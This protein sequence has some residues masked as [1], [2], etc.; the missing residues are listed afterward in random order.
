MITFFF[1]KH[2]LAISFWGAIVSIALL[3]CQ[4]EPIEV[5]S[6]LENRWAG[7]WQVTSFQHDGA[8]IKDKVVVSSNLH[9]RPGSSDSNG[10]FEWSIV[11]HDNDASEN[12]TGSYEI[13]KSLLEIT[14]TGDKGKLLKMHYAQHD[15]QL[16]L[17]GMHDD[18]PLLLIAQ[19]AERSVQK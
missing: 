12:I 5:T 1:K 17:S 15:N 8:E 7:Q 10:R 6:S 11:Y 9:F 14:F 4:A 16:K 19:R 13:N 2:V 18:V 3:G